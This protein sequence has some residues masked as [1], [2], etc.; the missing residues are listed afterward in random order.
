MFFVLS[1][2]LHAAIPEVDNSGHRFLNMDELQEEMDRIRREND[3]ISNDPD[4]NL[5]EDFLDPIS[6][7]LMHDPVVAADGR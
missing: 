6:F 4:F 7:E 1:E 3:E 5:V 2:T